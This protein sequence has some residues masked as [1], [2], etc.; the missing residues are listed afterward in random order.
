MLFM[1]SPL[2][3]IF[4]NLM[5]VFVVYVLGPKIMANRKALD[6]KNSIRI[7]NIYQIV[8]STYLVTRYLQLGFNFK[9]FAKC[10]HD[11]EGDQYEQISNVFWWNILL[12]A[13]EFIETIFFV[14]RKKQ[15]QV[16]FLH[17][18]HHIMTLVL[19]WTTLK[20]GF[21]MSIIYAPVLNGSVHVVMYS[22][23]LISSFGSMKNVA[24]ILKNF[25][26]PIQIVQLMS[27]MVHCGVGFKSSCHAPVTEAVNLFHT[28]FLSILFI[29]F[30]V[31]SKLKSKTK[32]E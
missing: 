4:I 9:Y 2:P 23:Y 7:Y 26:T 10:H 32:K 18:Y 28:T 16:S 13:S 29:K 20:Y 12:R 6:C 31:D 14:L 5:Y 17:V 25:I 22:Y 27:G 30:F 19:F 21:I 3:L 11:F 24:R 8:A 15:E 1:S